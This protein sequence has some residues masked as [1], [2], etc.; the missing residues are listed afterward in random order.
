MSDEEIQKKILK[1]LYD[2][3]RD[4]PLEE[5]DL[6]EI[7]QEGL[8][9]ATR[10]ELYRNAD[11]LEE[12][13]FIRQQKTGTLKCGHCYAEVTGQGIDLIENKRLSSDVI[14]RRKILEVL[15]DASNYVA[16]KEIVRQTGFSDVKVIRNI[17]Y[18]TDTGKAK[19]EWGTVGFFSAKITAAG[20]DNL[21]E[22]TFLEKQTIFM[23][24]AYLTLYKLENELRTFI[25]KKL[26][27][28][29]SDEWWQKGVPLRVRRSA[30]DNKAKEPD[31][32]LSLLCYILF[33]DLKRIIQKNWHSIFKKYFRTLE[34]I[35]FKLDQLE[36]IRHIIAHTRLLSNEDSKKLDLFHKE[37][38]KTIARAF[39]IN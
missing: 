29:Y 31:S 15:R 36:D 14:I 35:I 21:K 2:V 20:I 12:K 13:G 16:K 11:Y 33:S 4:N 7:I 19:A 24:N 9:T 6:G 27:E 22:P 3:W 28:E 17:K 32:S 38:T 23:S 26:R 25:E 37:I 5:L 18:L 10:D 1:I 8:L 39:Y 30:E 34:G